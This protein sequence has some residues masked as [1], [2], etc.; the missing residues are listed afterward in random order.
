MTSLLH[1]FLGDT[2]TTSYKSVLIPSTNLKDA[3]PDP[4]TTTLGF[5]GAF[6]SIGVAIILGVVGIVGLVGLR[7][8]KC[9]LPSVN[10][11]SSR[12][13]KGHENRT[14]YIKWWRRWRC[15]CCGGSGGD[16]GVDM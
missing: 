3:H 11:T 9:N 15:C 8:T 2:T 16:D 14:M 10:V 6:G 13:K 5:L 7:S 1:T 4:N 12:K